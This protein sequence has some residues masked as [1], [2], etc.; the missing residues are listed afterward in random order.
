MIP[1]ETDFRIFDEI[2]NI[3][4][5]D[6]VLIDNGYVYHTI[7]DSIDKIDD[8]S[9]HHGGLTV[10]ELV[11]ELAG[12]RD[13][14]GAHLSGS[15]RRGRLY[16][17]IGRLTSQLGLTERVKHDNVVFFDILHRVTVVYDEGMALVINFCVLVVTVQIWVAKMSNMEKRDVVGAFR[18][19]AVAL[20]TIPAAFASATFASFVY[21]ELL[22]LK[23]RWYGST[24][25]ACLIFGPPTLHGTISA[26]LLLLPKRLSKN[27][28]DQMLFAVT[29]FYSVALVLM[30]AKKVMSNYIPMVLLI[31]ADICAIEG[32][33][34][35][36]VVKHMEFLM[37]HG[38]L[39]AKLMI[40]SFSST[41]PIVGRIRSTAV[42]HDT[43]AALIV[44][45]ILLVHFIISSLPILCHYATCLRKLRM[46]TFLTSIGIAIFFLSESWRSG[47][48]R[49]PSYSTDA[50]KRISA[51]HFYS[52]QMEPSSVLRLS[53]WDSIPLQLD[54]ITSGRSEN[55]KPLASEPSWGTL[56]STSLESFRPFRVFLQD[57]TVYPTTVKPDLP[58]PTAT[59]TSVEKL[60]KGWNISVTVEALDAHMFSVRLPVGPGSAVTAWSLDAKL[61]GDEGGAW[62]KHTG[63]STFM[64]WLL[65][66]GVNG[67][68]SER[69]KI[70][71]ALASG[72]MGFT[73]SPS[74]LQVLRFAEWEAP[75]VAVCTGIEVEL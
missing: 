60:Q 5:Y 14:I 18:M 63:T 1:A 25:K 57:P 59:V 20:L 32:A 37:A 30:T 6:F 12:K 16:E 44:S 38:I 24:W 54:R 55:T 65:V 33:S 62:I 3:P 43:F 13:A 10:F 56:Q 26:M 11:M 50:P 39:G 71:M 27:R 69:P 31:V 21:A 52:P 9:V 28:F 41:L 58:V 19:L 29:V 45:G 2:G 68:D 74:E 8:T 15:S 36:P 35:H 51:I 7:Y 70:T 66:D 53:P 46:C 17:A 72:R 73:K 4:G 42:P 40:D 47:D 67:D 61:N 49:H 22:N 75:A 23:L 64:F 48:L 34:V